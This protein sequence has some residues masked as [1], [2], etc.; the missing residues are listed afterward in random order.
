MNLLEALF[1]SHHVFKSL[2]YS[3]TNRN[4]QLESSH[5]ANKKFFDIGHLLSVT[6]KEIK[7]TKV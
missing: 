3:W 1:H 6:C 5:S 4:W 2:T 7:E